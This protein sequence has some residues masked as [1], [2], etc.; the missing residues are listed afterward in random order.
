MCLRRDVL[1]LK[2][3]IEHFF[4]GAAIFA[5]VFGTG[6]D[7]RIKRIHADESETRL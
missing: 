1:D 3:K 5:A 2:R 6:G 4:R 7:E